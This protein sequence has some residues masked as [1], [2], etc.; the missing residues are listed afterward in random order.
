MS[1]LILIYGLPGAGKTTLAA[2][3]SRFGYVYANL[4][5][6][7]EFG[8]RAMADLAV[9]IFTLHPSDKGLVVEAVLANRTTRVRFLERIQQL[10][11]SFDGQIFDRV[12][13]FY[14][15]ETPEVLSRRRNRTTAQYSELLVKLEVGNPPFEHHILDGQDGQPQDVASRASRVKEILERSALRYE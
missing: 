1:S 2:E 13:T 12:V 10:R 5:R 8:Q 4:A 6:H 11:R 15:S 7:P 14:L 9:Q 3:L